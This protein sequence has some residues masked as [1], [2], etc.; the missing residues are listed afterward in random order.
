MNLVLGIETYAC[1]FDGMD[2]YAKTWLEFVFPA[3][4]WALVGAIIT[5]GHYS[6]TVAKSFGSN[7]ISVLATLIL[8]SYTKLL[9][10]IITTFSLTILE[11]PNELELV[12]IFDGNIRLSHR[13]FIPLFLTAVLALVLLF[14]P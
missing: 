7:P 5:L 6:T 2:A 10:T 13:F 11:Y 4:V 14:I 3:Y 9:C 12:W 8:L 1:L